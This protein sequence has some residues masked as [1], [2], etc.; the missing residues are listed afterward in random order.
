MP[1]DTRPDADDS[2]RPVEVR[3]CVAC[4]AAAMMPVQI[5]AHT[6]P[7]ARPGQ[8]TM[9]CR[10]Q[11]CGAAVTLFDPKV[12]KDERQAGL[13]LVWTLL[14][15]LILLP[16]AARHARAWTDH[17]VVPGAPIPPLRFDRPHATRRCGACGERADL[18]NV[19]ES[20]A[21][22]VP[23]GTDRTYRCSR[24]GASF[25]TESAAGII[26]SLFG[27]LLFLGF[28]LLSLLDPPGTHPPFERYFLIPAAILAGAWFAWSAVRAVAV[29]R[30][31]PIT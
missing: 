21:N 17:P 8:R 9:D 25:T 22:G 27:S 20:R 28:G 4:G 5:W 6:G 2:P 1:N 7:F 12:I 14:A 29:N 18:T 30:R 11:A 19:H 31:N 16:R 3:R 15:P 10:C 24:C 26:S 13:F 23:T